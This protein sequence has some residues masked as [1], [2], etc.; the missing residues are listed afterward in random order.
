MDVERGTI[1]MSAGTASAQA[2]LATP[3]PVGKSFVMATACFTGNCNYLARNLV[4]VEL[5]DVV[6]SDYTRVTAT[7][8]DSG[9]AVSVE[10]QVITDDDFTVQ[11]GNQVMSSTTH[12]ST[13]TAVDTTAAFVVI[14]MSSTDNT[15]PRRSLVRARLTSSIQIELYVNVAGYATATWYVVEWSGA[16]VQSGTVTIPNGSTSATITITAVDLAKTFLIFNNATDTLSSS[17]TSAYPFA[18]GTF[19]NTTTMLFARAYTPNSVYI[20]A[21][22][23]SHPNMRVQYGTGT[24]SGAVTKIHNIT[25]TAVQLSH[26]I[27]VSPSLGSSYIGQA[28]TCFHVVLVSH[29][30]TA[31]TNLRV[32]RG[33]SSGDTYYSW[34]VA[35]VRGTAGIEN[36]SAF[37]S[38]KLVAAGII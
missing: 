8:G 13:I 32:T 20:S 31:A 12:T 21:F 3:V 36:K 10:W 30:L 7:R 22:A 11:T 28:H 14:S 35:D 33:L 16:T 29:S 19:S 2:T 26:A 17:W 23:V 34:F 18:R 27:A 4:R 15:E 1:A 5:T 24:I 9:E 38:S 6:G 25:I 37:M